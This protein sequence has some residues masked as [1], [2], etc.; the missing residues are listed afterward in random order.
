MSDYLQN[1]F[2]DEVKGLLNGGSAGNLEEKIAEL[3]GSAPENLDTLEE[4]AKVLNNVAETIN[5]VK[6]PTIT[7]NELNQVT[8]CYTSSIPTYSIAYGDGKFI[9]SADGGSLIYP[10]SEDLLKWTRSVPFIDPEEDSTVHINRIVYGNGMFIAA[11]AS[12]GISN[13]FYSYDG[14]NWTCGSRFETLTALAYC[15]GEFVLF[16]NFKFYRSTDGINWTEGGVV[17][18]YTIN[19]VIYANGMYV[20]TGNSCTMWHS[21]DGNT[22]VMDAVLTT[23]SSTKCEY[24]I[25]GNGVFIAKNISLPDVYHSTDGINW[26]KY[27]KKI[28]CVVYYKDRFVCIDMDQSPYTLSYSYDGINW[29]SAGEYTLPVNGAVS[30]IGVAGDDVIIYLNCNVVGRAPNLRYTT[31]ISSVSLKKETK[32]VEEAINELRNISSET[33]RMLREMIT[34]NITNYISNEITVI[35]NYAFYGRDSLELVHIPKVIS[36]GNYA[37]SSCSNLPSIDLPEVTEIGEYAF[38]DCTGLT[39][40]TFRTTPDLIAA[41]AFDGCIRLTRINVPWAEGEVINAPWGATNATI[42]Y[43]YT[44]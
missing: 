22:W 8:Q 33:N 31:T 36:I 23:V 13:I 29:I 27:E 26:I 39:S 21:T 24:L 35:G 5:E 12:S 28:E 43:N 17:E 4:L 9:C 15:N 38:K 14:I 19:N 11:S 40:V 2:I 1:L 7:I 10:S 30:S 41:T 3:V 34:G 25:Y 18:N 20:A 16:S 6:Y 42:N 37:F 44:E 32:T